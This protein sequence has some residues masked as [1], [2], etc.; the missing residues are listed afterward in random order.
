MPLTLQSALSHHDAWW[1]TDED[2][3]AQSVFIQS[4]QLVDLQRVVRGGTEGTSRFRAPKL[5]GGPLI[6]E[7]KERQRQRGLG[8]GVGHREADSYIMG[9]EERV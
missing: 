6:T 7:K 3:P 2:A 4:Y 8:D 9:E 1:Q 5:I